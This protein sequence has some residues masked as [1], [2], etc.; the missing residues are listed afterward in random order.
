MNFFSIPTGI[1]YF[2][3]FISNRFFTK[4]GKIENGSHF[5]CRDKLLTGSFDRTLKLWAVAKEDCIQ[6]YR[7]HSAEV[8]G[9]KFSPDGTTFASCSTDHTARIF[10]IT[11][12]QEMQ[13]LKHHIGEVIRLQYSVDGSMLLTGSFDNTV[14]V[15]DTRTHR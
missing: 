14:I 2:G 1:N 9:V 15:W 5:F 7:G 13:A 3:S 8:V 11:S 10:N 12:G 4:V 6:T